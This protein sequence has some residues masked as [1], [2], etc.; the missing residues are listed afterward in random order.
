MLKLKD[1]PGSEE[2]RESEAVK[3]ELQSMEENY[4]VIDVD[5]DYYR[6]ILTQD[7]SVRLRNLIQK[8]IDFECT[9]TEVAMKEIGMRA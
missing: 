1:Q 6:I 5:H 8:L 7:G 9:H 3:V 2:I 4:Q